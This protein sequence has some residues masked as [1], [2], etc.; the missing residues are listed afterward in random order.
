[1][2]SRA[3]TATLLNRQKPMASV[4]HRMVAWGR[5]RHSPRVVFAADDP[6]DSVAGTAGR[7]QGH[8]V[9]GRADNGVGLDVPP[10]DSAYAQTSST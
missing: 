2:A 5:T 6:L 3:A 7:H 9:A 10:P 1:M 4:D 8:V